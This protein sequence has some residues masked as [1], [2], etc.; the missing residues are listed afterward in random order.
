MGGAGGLGAGQVGQRVAVDRL[1]FGHPAEVAGQGLLAD[2]FGF[3]GVDFVAEGL[4]QQV[5]EALFVRRLRGEAL[6]DGGSHFSQRGGVGVL[7]LGDDAL[8]LLANGAQVAQPVGGASGIGRGGQGELALRGQV[9]DAGGVV[10]QDA[11]GVCQATAFAA[12]G[13][14]EH[15]RLDARVAYVVD[16]APDLVVDARALQRCC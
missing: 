14:R 16:A 15:L 2:G 1:D 10:L 7:E 12:V 6:L 4:V 8:Q 9:V 13:E 5:V 11:G 3:A